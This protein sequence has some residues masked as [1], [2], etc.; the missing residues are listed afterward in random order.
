L[1]GDR[2]ERNER[3]EQNERP[4]RE[5]PAG[6]TATLTLVVRDLLGLSHSA[7]KALIAGGRALVDGVPVFDP[8]DRPRPGARVAIAARGAPPARRPLEGPGFQVIRLDDDFVVVDKEP[9]IVTVPT[10]KESPED[11]P[12]VARVIAAMSVAGHRVQDGL[13]V[14]HRIDRSTSGLV[15]FARSEAASGELR[16][17]FRARQ[18]LR[19]YLAWTAG[20]PDPREGRLVHWLLENERS[21]RVH[22]LRRPETGAREAEMEYAVEATT[23]TEPRRAR[24]RVRLVTGRRN[25]IRVQLS[26][27]GWPIL[28][29]AFYGSQE[30]G[31]GRTALH[32][33]RLGFDHPRTGEPVICEAPLPTDLTKLD[34]RLFGYHPLVHRKGHR[35]GQE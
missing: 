11:P 24:V 5:V 33:A 19:E 18:P 26:S 30:E 21:R 17:Q 7:A 23:K 6:S 10:V 20:V 2:S 29:D 28:G 31:P 12:L 4:E 35:A 32:A 34:R 25:Q 3:N 8:A 1:G 13:W 15:L 22:A 9:G 14:V 16:A 27:S